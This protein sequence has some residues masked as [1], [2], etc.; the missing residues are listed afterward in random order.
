MISRIQGA[1][2][3]SSFS[4]PT[5][6]QASRASRSIASATAT[7]ALGLPLSRASAAAAERRWP[8]RTEGTKEP[9]TSRHRED[10]Q[11][12]TSRIADVPEHHEPKLLPF[13][14]QD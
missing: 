12:A 5:A 14:W 11:L 1:P 6:P 9:A 2:A 13:D 8:S 4:S 10:L 7:C 3:I